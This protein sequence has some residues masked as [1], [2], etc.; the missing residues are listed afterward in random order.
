MTDEQAP[1]ETQNLSQDYYT[2]RQVF[3]IPDVAMF[4]DLS[5]RSLRWRLYDADYGRREDGS[6]IGSQYYTRTGKPW[7][8]R[9]TL[10]DIRDLAHNFR[11][12]NILDEKGLETVLIRID[13]FH[14]PV[15]IKHANTNKSP[16]QKKQQEKN[17][18]KMKQNSPVYKKAIENRKAKQEGK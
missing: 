8:I 12:L 7:G 11:R 10:D 6:V 2:K 9:F 14:I 18:K 17:L 1:K 4:F 5:A 13:A 3:N 15:E 16:K